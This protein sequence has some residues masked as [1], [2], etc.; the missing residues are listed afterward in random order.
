VRVLI[1]LL[2]QSLIRCRA[3]CSVE[4]IAGPNSAVTQCSMVFPQCS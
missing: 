1:L 3:G 2:A 4:A